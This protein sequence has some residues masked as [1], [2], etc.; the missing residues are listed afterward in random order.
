MIERSS[1]AVVPNDEFHPKVAA[2]ADCIKCVVSI[3][4]LEFMHELAPNRL[5]STYARILFS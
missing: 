4:E 5:S 3:L 2:L 1:F